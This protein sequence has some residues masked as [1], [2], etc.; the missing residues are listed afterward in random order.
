M[1]KTFLH[2][3]FACFLLALISYSATAASVQNLLPARNAVK[4]WSVTPGSLQY[5]KGDDLTR[6][7]N[8]GYEL[9]TNNGVV[10]A[11]RQMY[12]RDND[13]VEVTIH[14]MKSDKA[15]SQ[16]LDYW[17]KQNK[18]KSLSRVKKTSYFTIAKP[19]T[20]VYFVTGKYF[21]T[22]SAFHA[23]DKSRKDVTAFMDTI[24]KAAGDK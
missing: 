19:N 21:T 20:A 10:D 1:R 2:T 5:G 12:Q 14:T 23:A 8:G 4:G 22:V 24:R 3:A 16:F 18:I 7:Y 17:R 15:A 11:A 9:Y 13:Y 6:I